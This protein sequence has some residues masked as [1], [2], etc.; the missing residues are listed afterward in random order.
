MKYRN[1]EDKCY[2]VAGMAIGLN[3]FDADDLMTEVNIDAD[4]IRESG[5][6]EVDNVVPLTSGCICCSCFARMS[7]TS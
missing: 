3:V 4:L 7:Q 2:G 1:E 6:A 5:A